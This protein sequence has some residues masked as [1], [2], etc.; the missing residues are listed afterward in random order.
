M[1]LQQ[2][3]AAFHCTLPCPPPSPPPHTHPRWRDAQ[4]GTLHWPSF[5]EAKRKELHRLNTAY[6][7]N[8]VKAGVEVVEGRGTV[9]GPHAVA[10]GDRQLSVS[11]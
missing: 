9:A 5:I 3:Y 11:G 1:P 2:P 6:T 10:V 4:P 8:L 7:D